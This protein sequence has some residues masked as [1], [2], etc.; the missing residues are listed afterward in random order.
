MELWNIYFIGIVSNLYFN[1][2]IEKTQP[3]RDRARD[4]LPKTACAVSVLYLIY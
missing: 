1:T 4:A 3:H 2:M